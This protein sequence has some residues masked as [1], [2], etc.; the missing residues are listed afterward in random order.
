MI[1]TQFCSTGF[2]HIPGFYTEA[3]LCEVRD[4]VKKIANYSLR[5]FRLKI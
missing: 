4:V 1:N 3:E 2:F 5:S